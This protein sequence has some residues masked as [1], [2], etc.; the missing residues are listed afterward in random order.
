LVWLWRAVRASRS[1][2]G[3]GRPGSASGGAYG[4]RIGRAEAGGAWTPTIRVM[5]LIDVAGL[6]SLVTML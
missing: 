6:S 1:C 3:V 4:E 2:A 5:A